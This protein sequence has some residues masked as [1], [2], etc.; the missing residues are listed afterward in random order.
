MKV[1]E[2]GVDGCTGYGVRLVIYNITSK[3]CSS[4]YQLYS[5]MTIGQM[6]GFLKLTQFWFCAEMHLIFVLIIQATLQPSFWL[7]ELINLTCKGKMNPMEVK[8]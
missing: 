2:R 4:Y 5:M 1:G 8:G 6:Y 7:L 3:Q